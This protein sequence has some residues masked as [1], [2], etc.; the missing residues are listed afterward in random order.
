MSARDE[1]V[2]LQAEAMRRRSEKSRVYF[3]DTGPYRRDLY[4]K[5]VEFFSLGGQFRER[6]FMA[7][8]RIG[9]SGAGAFEVCCHAT[10]NYPHWWTGK[11]FDQSVDVWACGTNG[12]TTRDIVQTWLLGDP[13]FIGEWQ[14]S[15]IPAHLI[16]GFNRRSHGLANALESVTVRHASGGLSSIAFKS[17]E[18]GRPSFEGT[19][20]HVIWDDEEPPLDVYTEQLLRITTTKGCVLVTFTPLLGMSDVVTSFLEPTEAAREFKTYVQAGWKHVPHLDS[21]ATRALLATMPP[22]QVK[23]RSEG[24]PVLGSGAIYPINEEDLIIP[25]RPIPAGWPRGYGFDVGWNRTAVIWGARDPGNHVWELYDSHYKSQGEPPSHAAGIQ[26]RGEWMHGAI[27]PASMGSSVVD[28][29]IAFDEYMKLGLNL[30]PAINAVEAGITHVWTLMITGR[31][32]VQSH[33]TDWLTEFRRYHRNEKGVIVKKHD[34][35]MDATRYLTM[36]AADV[37]QVPP[38]PVRLRDQPRDSHPQSW[39]GS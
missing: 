27:D 5:H 29:R 7:A 2:L 36:T 8:N 19:S 24:E 6:L 37:L 17:Y 10:G 26:A 39:M 21:E 9:K 38:G 28:G 31:L 16:E 33:L 30:V 15:M 22:H 13:R 32:R 18:Q 12:E 4:P 3:P 25:T 1:Q 34:H 23:A 11:R 14:G 20:K 35:L